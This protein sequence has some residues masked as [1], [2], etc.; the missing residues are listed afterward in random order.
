MTLFWGWSKASSTK[1]FFYV[2]LPIL[3]K[4][5]QEFL[6]SETYETQLIPGVPSS[7]SVGCQVTR[8]DLRHLRRIGSSKCRHPLLDCEFHSF[9]FQTRAINVDF[10]S[11]K[12]KTI[13]ALQ[14]NHPLGFTW[15]KQSNWA[16]QLNQAT[17]SS[18]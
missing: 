16:T 2:S 3:L 15:K 14:K 18:V 6:K 11:K 1:Q 10:N 12:N 8:F 13:P 5:S 7:S 4:I 9:L 17:Q